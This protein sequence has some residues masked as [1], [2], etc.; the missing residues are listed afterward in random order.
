MR[1]RATRTSAPGEAW[2]QRSLDRVGLRPDHPLFRK[3]LA[4]GRISVTEA[5]DALTWAQ[6]VALQQDNVFARRV[7]VTYSFSA[8]P[9]ETYIRHAAAVAAT[10]DDA[11]RAKGGHGAGA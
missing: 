10:A 8:R 6:R 2:T 5:M 7:D 1:N 11:A 4:N 3:L 9:V